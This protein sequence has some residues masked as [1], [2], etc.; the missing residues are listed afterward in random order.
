[1]DM[2]STAAA[3]RALGLAPGITLALVPRTVTV[4][5]ALPIAQ[6]LGASN[7]SITAAVVVLSGLLGAAFAQARRCGC[8]L[9]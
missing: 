8:F 3:G 2:T 7:G 1:M 9:L 5:L 4:A 6:L